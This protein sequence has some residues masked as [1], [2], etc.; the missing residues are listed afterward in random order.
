MEDS[1]EQ[2]EQM[3][4]E[5][6]S[7][8]SD[9]A[10]SPSLGED[11]SMSDISSPNSIIPTVPDI[12]MLLQTQQKT[13]TPGQSLSFNKIPPI[14]TQSFLGP[15][16]GSSIFA[17]S[18]IQSGSKNNNGGNG[19]KSSSSSGSRHKKHKPKIQAKAKVIKF[20]EYK[21]PPNVVKTQPAAPSPPNPNSETPYHVMLQQQQLFLQWQL[22][23]K[24]KNMPFTLSN[25]KAGPDGTSVGMPQ[26]SPSSMINSSDNSQSCSVNSVSSPPPAP[27]LP[28]QLPKQVQFHQP[29]SPLTQ[30]QKS[31]SPQP[32]VPPPPPPPPPASKQKSQNSASSNSGAPKSFSTFDEMKVA[33]LKVE[34]KKRNLPVSGPKPQLIERLRPFADSILTA[35][36]SADSTTEPVTAPVV[37]TLP[38][39]SAVVKVESNLRMEPPVKVEPSIKIEPGVQ[40]EESMNTGSPPISP[41]HTEASVTPMSPDGMDIQSPSNVALGVLKSQFSSSQGSI[42][43]IVDQI[44]RPPS[45]APMEIAPMET[46]QTSIIHSV[47][48]FTQSLPSGFKT[49]TAVAQPMPLTTPLLNNPQISPKQDQR[50]L[51]QE[52]LLRQQQKKIEEL[53][54]QLQQSQLQLK[55]HQEQQRLLQQQKLLQQQVQQHQQQ[56]A[57]HQTLQ[58]LQLQKQQ[59][60]KQQLQQQQSPKQVQHVQSPPLVQTQSTPQTSTSVPSPQSP[61]QGVSTIQISIVDSSKVPQLQRGVSGA[62]QIQIPVHLLQAGQ[63]L[64]N[65]TSALPAVIVSSTGNS[66][67]KQAKPAVTQ[68]Q[69]VVVPDLNLGKPRVS[70]ATPPPNGQPFIFSSTADTST[71]TTSEPMPPNGIT[72]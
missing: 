8:Q 37:S 72:R 43:M 71:K 66:P 19:N 9:S 22:E 61:P 50:Q 48:D 42:P 51:T 49:F 33:D 55:I 25:A 62:Q 30:I 56:L 28:G 53:Q 11:S 21:G 16:S 1:S 59:Q 60:Q 69:A 7:N 34:L 20:H 52:E 17:N 54:R 44:S 41:T 68:A 63:A 29:S 58:K 4:V 27:P 15:A 40:Q 14:T 23:F 26:S 65:S 24:Q 57:K 38:S 47:A 31:P 10:P 67:T 6:D 45:A 46:D 2:S 13:V 32:V 35:A 18:S 12:S 3:G 70:F 36:Q 5:E 39:V 64:Q